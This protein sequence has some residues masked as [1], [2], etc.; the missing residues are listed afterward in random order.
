[1]RH[2]ILCHITTSP[3]PASQGILLAFPI[4]AG[5]N[6]LRTLAGAHARQACHAVQRLLS[7]ESLG[8][9]LLVVIAAS[10][11][12]VR[13][14]PVPYVVLGI[15][16]EIC[17]VSTAAILLGGAL[18]VTQWRPRAPFLVAALAASVLIDVDHVPLSWFSNAIL[19]AGTP[20]PYPHALWFIAVL[21]IAAR[22]CRGTESAALLAGA[23]TG[24][25]LHLMRDV[26]TA[27]VAM[28]WPATTPSFQIDYPWYFGLLAVVVAAPMFWR[29][30]RE[31]ATASSDRC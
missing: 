15:F 28:L 22:M 3:V 11:V 8:L 19:T 24:V 18:Q 16:D 1:M 2:G 21:L 9:G 25:G 29:R 23:A 13:N 27:P 4:L 30:M 12:L 20:R 5:V 7:R 10:D 6:A 17:H 14:V 26:A 31:Q